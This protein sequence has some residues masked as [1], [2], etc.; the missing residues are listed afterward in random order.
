MKVVKFG[1]TSLADGAAYEK[2]VKIIQDDPERT[3][4]V[5]SA[6]GKRFQGDIKVTDLLIRYANQVC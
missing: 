5:T 2:V 3:V 1:G 4:I 6:P